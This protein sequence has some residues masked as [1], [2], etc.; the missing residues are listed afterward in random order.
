MLDGITDRNAKRKQQDLRNDKE[1]R[2]KED[3]ADG[4]SVVE[5]TEDKDKL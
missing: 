2:A 1:G 5:R 3:I 4:P